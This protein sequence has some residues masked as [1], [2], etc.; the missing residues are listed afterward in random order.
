MEEV[1]A[2]TV[3]EDDVSEGDE[4]VRRFFPESWLFEVVETG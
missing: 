4:A 1:S 3:D 2:I